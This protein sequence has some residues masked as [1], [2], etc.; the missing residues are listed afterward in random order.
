MTWGE[1]LTQGTSQLKQAGIASPNLDASLLLAHILG[2][3]REHLLIY[4][5]RALKPDAISR[6][7]NLVSRRIAGEN[8]AYLTGYKEFWGLSFQ[9]SSAVLVPRPDT[10]ILVETVLSFLQGQNSK[11]GQSFNSGSYSLLDLCTGSGAVAIALKSSC[12]GLEV[13]ASDISAPALEIAHT[14]ARRLLSGGQG[15]NEG[16][17]PGEEQ[18]SGEGQSFIFGNHSSKKNQ[19]V[20]NLR[21]NEAFSGDRASEDQEDQ[22]PH[23]GQSFGH[24]QGQSITFYLSDL[25]TAIPGTFDIIVS[26][27]PYIPSGVL[28]ELPREV[29]KE[30][31]IALDGGRDGLDLIKKIISGGHRRLTPGGILFLEADPGQMSAITLI[32]TKEGFQNILVY[33][34]LAGLERVISGKRNG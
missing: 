20:Q 11:E 23:G 6:F 7:L 8:I 2:I 25:Y 21:D 34:D 4:G 14:N 31:R 18:N 29:Q 12:P 28:A 30:P 17:S 24:G 13:S 19:K 9:V 27:P 10:E 3:D 33:R 5:D 1:I 26:N 22:S 15:S 16:Q 32:L